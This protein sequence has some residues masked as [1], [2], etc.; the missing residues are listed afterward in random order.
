MNGYRSLHVCGTD[1]YGTATEMKALQEGTTPQ[2]I[3]ERYFN[4]HKQI[5][6]WFSIDFDIFGRTSTDE[7]TE[8]A[9]RNLH[10]FNCTL[11][12]ICQDMFLK[13]HKQ[14]FTS[15]SSLDQLHCSECNKFL[16][17]RY[18]FGTCPLCGYDDARGDQCDKCAK[19]LDAINLINP[20]CQLC[21]TTPTVKT[22]EHI[23]LDLTK[24]S[25]SQ[26]FKFAF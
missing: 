17:D 13:L 8:Y 12:R 3:C 19:L 14:G 15:T 16:A 25:A 9:L 1:E 4:L 24:L 26:N 2:E 11:F 21:G 6:E 18:V 22:S 5:Y 10:L 23:F 7:Q 20:K